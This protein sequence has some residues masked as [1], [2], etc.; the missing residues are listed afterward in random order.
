M[1]IR[2]HL[3]KA[4]YSN[5][6]G[7]KLGHNEMIEEPFLKYELG[8]LN[9]SFISNAHD[10][11][12]QKILDSE[13][14]LDPAEIK[15]EQFTPP[16][17]ENTDGD[18][19]LRQE[20]DA[21]LNPRSGALSLGLHFVLEGDK[22]RFKICITWARYVQDK[23]FGDVPR[24]FQRHSN[25]FV[26]DWIRSD[27]D[28]ECIELK[29]NINESIVTH[30]GVFLHILKRK[31]KDSEK[32]VIKIFL[33][34]RTK[35][36]TSK[37]QLE[38]DRVFQPQI[39]VVTE[40]S[41]LA[42]LDLDYENVDTIT[43]NDDDLIYQNVRTKARGFLCAAIWKEVDPEKE[44]NSEIGKISWPDSLSVPEN[45]RKM[46]T[47]P[48]IRTEFL[49]LYTILQPDQSEKPAFN[50]DILSQ[51]WDPN[52]IENI[53]S[54][55]V[56]NYSKWIG[57]QKQIL[58]EKR[59]RGDVSGRLKS[60]GD[61]NLQECIAANKR[62]RKGIDFLKSNERAKAAFCFM[63]AVMNDKRT[64]EEG[65][66]LNWR[67]F[68]MAFILQSLRGV[69]GKSQEEQSL[70]DVLWFPTGGGKTEAYLGIVI[71]AMAYRR[72]M[73]DNEYRN[74]GGVSVISRYTLRL[75]TIQQFQRS[76]GAIV[77]A[78]IR[79]VE[80][81]LPNDA[82][83]GTE[84]ISD[85]HIRQ[86]FEEGTLWGNQRFSIGIWIGDTTPKNFAY[87]TASQGKKILNSE[88]ALLPQWHDVR[89]HSKES[90][91]PAQ[92]Q[93][94][95]V[96][97]NILCISKALESS[98]KPVT[99]TWIINTCKSIDD[100]QN[101]PKKQFER[102]NAITLTSKPLFNFISD[103]A[104]G[105]HI[106]RM[107][108]EMISAQNKQPL[109]RDTVDKWW[110]DIVQPNLDPNP[111]NNSLESTCA[112]MPGY[113]FLKVPGSRR[114]HDFAIFCTN[115]ECKL[116][117]TRW[118]EKIEDTYDTIVPE[119]FRINDPRYMSRSVPIS[120]FTYDEQIYL[121]CP[122]FL[123]ATVD[124]FANLPFEPKCASLFGN[125]DT[126]HPVYGYG[127][128]IIF[129]APLLQINK[130]SRVDIPPEELH[131][132]SGFNP[133]SLILQDELHLIEGPL[134]SM[135]GVYEMA[136][137]VLSTNNNL[138]PKYIASSATIKE[139]KTQVGT[140]F[141]RDIA[142]FPPI[143]INSS[144]NY[145]SKIDEDISCV[146]QQPGRLYL[147]IASSKSTITL[148]IKTQ[149]IIMSEIH[150]IRSNPEDYGL[151]NHTKKEINE[152]IEPYWTFVSYFTDLQL[153][154]KFTNFYPE[155]I[156]DN[157]L[158][159]SPTQIFNS[160]DRSP[161]NSVPP[162]LRLFPFK[163]DKDIEVFSLSIYCTNNTGKIKIAIYKDGDPIGN[164]MHRF[165]YQDCREGE[166]VF[167]LS[168]CPIEIKNGDK[169]WIAVIN[170]SNNTSFEMVSQEKNSL[171]S[172]YCTD[173]NT[174]DFPD[175]FGKLDVLMKD[176]I[177]ISL[178]SSRRDLEEKNCIQL[179]SA[180]KSEELA[181]NL[182]RLKERLAVDC[183][184]TSPVFGTGIDV[185]RL[186]LMEI[187]NQPKTNSGY[188]QSSGRVGRS[189]PGLVIN[190]LRAGRARDLNHYENFIGYHK[191]LH[192]FVEPITASPFSEKAMELCLGPIM[193]SILRNA[194]FVLDVPVN[195]HW[196]HSD[197]PL[198]MAQHNNDP[199]IEAMGKALEAI[200]SSQFIAEFRQMKKERFKQIFGELKGR[201]H[202]MAKDFQ[203]D[204]AR[205]FEYSERRPHA[206]PSKNVVLGSPNHADLG[207][208]FVYGNA[209]NSLRQTESVSTFYRSQDRSVQIRPSQFIVRYGPGSLISDKISTWA[210][211]NLQAL[212]QNLKNVGNFTDQ[213]TRGDTGL[214]KYEV[215][216]SRMKRIIHKFNSKTDLKK[217]RLF[218]LPSNSSLT[219][220]DLKPVYHCDTFPSWAI[221]HN[222]THPSKRVLVKISYENN[223][224]VVKC[225]ECH[226]LSNGKFS[227]DFYSS[228][229]VLACKKGHLGDVDW[230]FEVHRSKGSNC[231]GDTFE[232]IASGS[233]DDVRIVCL[234]HWN[235]HT[236]SFVRSNCKSSTTFIELKTRS[237]NGQ[238]SCNG[239]FV[240]SANSFQECQKN[241]GVSLAKMVSKAQMSLRMPVITTTMEI[242]RYKSILLKCYL[243]LKQFI[244]SIGLSNPNFTKDDFITRLEESKG[245]L[246][247]INNSLIRQTRTT[248]DSVF[249]DVIEDVKKEHAKINEKQKS[250]TEYQSLEEELSSLE[251]QTRDQGLGSQIGP[252][253]PPTDIRF[254]I[255]FS[256]YGLKFEAM[257]FENI[258]VTQ[259]QSGYTREV[260]PPTPTR[261]LQT[262]SEQNDMLRI[263]EIVSHSEK[264]TDEHGNIWYLA[265]QLQ[266]EGIFI[267]LD[268]TEHTDAMD[269]FKK[270]ETKP[271]KNWKKIHDETVNKNN[272]LSQHYK[273]KEK[274]EQHI[275]SLELEKIFTNPL[276]VWWHSFTHELINQLSIDSGF[277]GVSLGE[278]VYC[279][280]KRS[281]CYSAGL[282]IYA[283]TP[284][285]DGTLGGLTSLVNSE[286]LPKIVNRVLNKIRSCSN[287]P[288]CSDR[289]INDNRRT[290]AACHI[291]LMNS[292]TSC[293]YQNKFLDRNIILETS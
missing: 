27:S 181:R 216:D 135:V 51:T 172:I 1:L 166:N 274:S 232:W 208:D 193:V 81:W 192:R 96:C 196:I 83:H 285:A 168:S 72:L 112:S 149:S 277:M 275:E 109:D 270:S 12:H 68:Q 31:I 194:R 75:L 32:Y 58:D 262:L 269:V 62:I 238:M 171:E 267:H 162:G 137:D 29:N 258:R 200:A 175:S 15:N 233:N 92:I 34:N 28:D 105:G 248:P 94:C 33:E 198:R 174:D 276:F 261:S 23:Q 286:I 147:G 47:N 164:N 37:T 78:D 49:P 14:N 154:S 141:R 203:D 273:N 210:V 17:Y 146:A 22:P 187:M 215:N 91:D 65:E 45:I 155:N 10:E 161:N 79:R 222:K 67:E 143:G 66:S 153:L 271:F 30:P 227:T 292:E 290:G 169:I 113:F 225:P 239:R 265:N 212:V 93:T 189:K 9:S 237:K 71:F 99:L 123:I 60:I 204:R 228:R 179:S 138:R 56:I 120:A 197:G 76:L 41:T 3:V 180:T 46:F 87:T 229:Y 144:D 242:Q 245:M 205:P 73:A 234:G 50:A 177:K 250:L 121:K 4:L 259:V 230:K 207:L 61:K 188:I 260:Q 195:P 152:E 132:V 52:E 291:C 186:G 70:I 148:P 199:E 8:I 214:D 255:R 18:N 59:D 170:D 139:A 131:N 127:R 5:L 278:R 95:P 249:N 243:P 115:K 251:N 90:G 19:N 283:S 77:A 289:Q 107:S 156:K 118:F 211:P 282:F 293:S 101:I 130:N 142:T 82:Q 106:Y 102:E 264:Y 119:P 173:P 279:V 235:E 80:N 221:C 185:D 42:D 206:Q 244:V 122:S 64:N 116:N 24:M 178:N 159:W 253:D 6:L 151:S 254:P 213:N 89:R 190:W 202:Q 43:H 25:F 57:S 74:D 108:L 7:P 280:Q 86:K 16:D 20:I 11:H 176:S 140:I 48:N 209:P 54:P 136:V 117:K 103:S 220:N 236:N 35:Y 126:V 98:R 231:K 183:L 125:V 191:M 53:L 88:G 85:S 263:G 201:W 247:E 100:L 36:D 145:F 184:Q 241:G 160:G 163:S 2:T 114:P 133:P 134:G 38:K 21:E 224:Q 268:P 272:L 26:T 217:L 252:E 257:P 129:E 158:H 124:K 246:S 284:G 55:I 13:I 110:K 111:E 226:S 167:H 39:R 266:G 223:R 287:D 256:S 165:D 104:E 219:V 150:K 69:S 281:G 128:R 63:N 40:N 97:K 240:E 288:V 84:K 218:S 157:V 44:Q 182:D